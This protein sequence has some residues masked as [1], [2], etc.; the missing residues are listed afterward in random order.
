MTFPTKTVERSRSAG[1]AV[2]LPDMPFNQM[3]TIPVTLDL[4]STDEGLRMFTYPVEEIEKIHGKK[5]AWNNEALKPGE[6]PLEDVEGNLFDIDAKIAVGDADEVGLVI[7]GF[8]IVYS[9]NEQRLIG[10]VGKKGD[11]FSS[12]ETHV[13][14][15]RWRTAQSPSAFS[16]TAPLSKYSRTAGA[17]TCPCRPYAT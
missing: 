2:D 9:V 6:N 12:G 4:R 1:P 10:G 11:E 5:H 16:W 3:M 14:N 17:S 13:R 8:P 15:S 7:N